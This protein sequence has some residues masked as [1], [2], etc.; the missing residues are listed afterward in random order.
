LPR[1]DNSCQVRGWARRA[2]SAIKVAEEATE[3]AAERVEGGATEEVE[4]EAMEE[5][6]GEVTEEATE[7]GEGEAM[8]GERRKRCIW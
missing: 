2:S 8:R 6:T 5:A 3:E 1:R 4:G 7:E